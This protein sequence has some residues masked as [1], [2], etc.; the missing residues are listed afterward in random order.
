MLGNWLEDD[1][2]TTPC[3]VGELVRVLRISADVS[4]IT[5]NVDPWTALAGLP[6]ANDDRVYLHGFLNAMQLPKPH[7]YALLHRY[8]GKW[9]KAASRCHNPNGAD[10]A[11]RRAA[12]AWLLDGAQG[13][14]HWE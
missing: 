11:G 8:R 5:A 7:A 1:F 9:E 10:N 13:F 14:I 12:N 6:L 2:T 3:P 4:G